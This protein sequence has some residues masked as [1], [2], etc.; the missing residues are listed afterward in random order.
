MMLKSSN[1][2]WRNNPKLSHKVARNSMKSH[3]WR[4]NFYYFGLVF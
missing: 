1:H 3:A 2:P 4:E